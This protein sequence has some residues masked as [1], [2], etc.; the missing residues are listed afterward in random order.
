MVDV[1]NFY[2]YITIQIFD[3]PFTSFK[4]EKSIKN[5][6]RKER[7]LRDFKTQERKLPSLWLPL[8]IFDPKRDNR[9]S[10]LGKVISQKVKC[11]M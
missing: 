11:Q 9:Q 7:S 2:L 1:C 5:R 6:G 4:K 3:S 8:Q 10:G